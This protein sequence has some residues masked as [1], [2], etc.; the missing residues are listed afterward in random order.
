MREAVMSGS[1]THCFMPYWKPFFL[2]LVFHTVPEGP[3]GKVGSIFIQLLDPML[4]MHLLQER[5]LSATFK[6]KRQRGVVIYQP[7]SR[8]HDASS[9][10]K[11][12]PGSWLSIVYVITHNV[13]AN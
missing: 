7:Q 6:P 8:V 10:R 11:Y 1:G 2:Y 3:C 13:H 5:A 4:L 9:F 12:P